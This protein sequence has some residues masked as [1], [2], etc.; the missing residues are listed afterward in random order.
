M[1][2]KV[3]I[4]C[5]TYNHRNFIEKCL[6]GFLS[7]KVNFPYEILIH[8]DASTDGTA[9]IIREY[10]RKYPDIIKPIYETE[11]QWEKGRR[12]SAVFNFPR[13]KGEYIALCE[14]DDYWI[15]KDKLQKQVSFLDE[16]PDYGLIYTEFDR[17]LEE[18]RKFERSG[19][20]NYHGI[21]PNNFEDFLV[22]AWFLAPCTWMFRSDLFWQQKNLFTQGLEP[23][24]FHFLLIISKHSKVFFSPESTSVYRVLKKSLS[25]MIVD[26]NHLKFNKDIFNTQNYHSDL[27]SVSEAVKRKIKENFFKRTYK[28][29]CY[30]ND[31]VLKKQAYVFLRAEKNLPVYWALLYYI[32]KFRMF[33]KLIIWKRKVF[34]IKR[35]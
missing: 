35:R 14:G 4:C 17:Y 19:F 22:N 34:H 29:A 31:L 9:D 13:A 5:L 21:H 24:D 27:F 20:K 11:N 26:K 33:R 1:N 8:D 12:G 15:D 2:Y 25:H 32:T 3:S 16:N 18:K 6:E 28:L 23:P 30:L 7:Q 10:E